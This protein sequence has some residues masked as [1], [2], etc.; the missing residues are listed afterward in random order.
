MSVPATPGILMSVSTMSGGLP[1]SASSP[2]FPP[3]A[4]V[5]SKPSPFRRLRSTS[6]IPISSSS[7]RIDGCALIAL[8]LDS[9]CFLLAPGRWE[10][11]GECGALPRS[12]FHQHQTAVR[13]HGALHD[14]EAKTGPAHAAGHE[15][16]E[17]ARTHV[18]RDAG[19]V[20]AHRERD[21]ARSEER[22]VGKERRSRGEQYA[23]KKNT[24]SEDRAIDQSR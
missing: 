9:R 3:C 1:L 15:R 13:I 10:I 12:R 2:A 6:R 21:G 24:V 18:L 19:A 8:P 5:T 23:Y 16:L 4:V 20:V 14:S 11:D 7:T 17:Q 22:R